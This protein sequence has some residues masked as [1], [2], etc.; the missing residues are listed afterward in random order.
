MT[1]AHCVR[2]GLCDPFDVRLNTKGGA[3]IVHLSD[4]HWFFHPDENVDVAVMSFAAP[5]DAECKTIKRT[6]LLTRDRMSVGDIGPGD[7]TYTV[8]LFSFVKTRSRN[9]PLVHVGHIAALPDTYDK[10]EVND[11]I[12]RD[13]GYRA[14]EGYVVQCAALPGASGSPV[15]VRKPIV[16]ADELHTHGADGKVVQGSRKPPLAYGAMFLLGL[17]Q[18]S[19][20]LNSSRLVNGTT[21]RDPA[22]YG[23][24]VPAQKILDVL[25][26]MGE[27]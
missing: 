9:I 22:G 7:Q 8:G 15:F 18:S 3:T 26:G 4:P 21:V 5:P 20:E 17:W 11:W 1:A 16:A 13:G 25:D 12:H 23:I 10:I 19:W 14:V 6:A 27:S 2:E 24:V